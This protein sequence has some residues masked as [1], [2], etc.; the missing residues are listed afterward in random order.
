MRI[1]DWSSD[2][3][4]SDLGDSDLPIGS[5]VCR[6]SLTLPSNGCVPINPFIPLSE[7]TQEALDYVLFPAWFEQEIKQQS[8]Q[9]SI[10]GDLFDGWA[11][12]ISF[13]TGGEYRKIRSEEHTPELQSLMR[14]SYAVFCLTKTNIT[15]RTQ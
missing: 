6:T 5:V 7:N 2:V 1:S 15:P 8:A 4:S 13:A 12:P 9:G 10:S 14:I 3:C 11:G